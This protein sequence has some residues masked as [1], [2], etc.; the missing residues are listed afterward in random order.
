VR[1]LLRLLPRSQTVVAV[2]PTGCG[3]TV[4]GA[5]VVRRTW[6]RVLWLAH[7]IELLEQ[8]RAEIIGAGVPEDRVGLLSGKLQSNTSAPVLVASV[9]MFNNEARTVPSADLVVIDEAHHVAAESYRAILEALP[10]A[11]VLGLTATPQRLDGRPMTFFKR[12]YVIAETAELIADGYLL[13]ASVYGIPKEKAQELVRHAGIVHGR[14][15][16]SGKWLEVSMKK[17]PLMGDIVSEWQR[18]AKD[19]RTI[20]FACSRDHGLAIAERFA[21]A[22]ARTAYLDAYT[23]R[24]S[25][26]ELLS[27]T[28]KLVKGSIR[29]VVNV[30]VL[31]EG[32][33]CPP[34]SCVIVARP[35]KSL[36][37]WRQMCGRGARPAEG[38]DRFLVLDHAGNTWRHG[39]PDSTIDWTLDGMP[40]GKGDQTLKLC[41]VCR[42]VISSGTLYCPQCGSEQPHDAGMLAE[43]A[44]RLELLRQTE[45][46]LERKRRIL[47]RLAKL[48]GKDEKWVTKALA[49]VV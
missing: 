26:D 34:V 28:G 46:E 3:K 43:Q 1:D 22:G 11:R 32:F 23:P 41:P 13:K 18:L 48:R 37:L 49:R 7:R 21:D 4:I 38:K 33:D 6:A 10:N 8:A 24:E 40:R 30:G 17:A 44:A 29:V 31:T 27:R 5:T 12:L 20:V 47:H 35:T 19:E 15:D 36:G 16:Y 39:F 42:L 45:G 25:R 9:D 14:K 2:G